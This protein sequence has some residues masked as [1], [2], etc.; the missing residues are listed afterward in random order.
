MLLADFFEH[1]PKGN[2]SY[3]NLAHIFFIVFGVFGSILIGYLVRNVEHKKIDK[4]LKICAIAMPF[5]DVV[6]WIW[7]IAVTK[8]FDVVTSLPL[9]FCSLVYLVL[10]VAAFSKNE[11]IKQ[12]ALAYLATMN[13]VAGLMG[14]IFNTHLN[15][16]PM[17]S[18][19]AL[20]SM[21]YHI[22]MLVIPSIIWFTKYY[23][24]HIS[25][26]LTFFIPVAIIFVPACI[27]DFTINADYMFLNGGKGTPFAILANVLPVP[28]YILVLMVAILLLV[29]LIFYVPTIVKYYKLK[30][31]TK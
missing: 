3:F 14:L 22:T 24:P 9:Y 18:F 26:T 28:V 16:Y 5:F 13:L 7:E 12:S 6:Y 21:F 31:Q 29:N 1:K 17:F 8:S 10:P 20:R 15:H 19:V 27:V 25:H 23:K 30:K 4:F 2:F 11:N